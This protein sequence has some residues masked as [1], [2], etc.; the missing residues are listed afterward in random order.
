MAKKIHITENLISSMSAYQVKM[1][2]A[3]LVENTIKEKQIADSDIPDSI[4]NLFIEA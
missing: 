3:F 4:R 1:L 2:V